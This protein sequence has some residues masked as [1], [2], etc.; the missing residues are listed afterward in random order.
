[1]EK[2][3]EEW[4]RRK[5]RKSGGQETVR[6]MVQG[7]GEEIRESKKCVRGIVEEKGEEIWGSRNCTTNG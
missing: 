5:V 7:K 4:L 3:Y 6:G 1:M 2:L